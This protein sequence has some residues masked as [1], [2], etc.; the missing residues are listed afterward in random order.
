MS[1]W[2][3]MDEQIGRAGKGL[4]M[5]ADL[6]MGIGSGV[7]CNSCDGLD[8]EVLHL[9]GTSRSRGIVIPK[10]NELVEEIDVCRCID[11]AY[12]SGPEIVLLALDAKL[13]D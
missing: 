11:G 8:G 10:L 4:L 2:I 7:I 9:P 6:A 1:T 5:S 3:R 13:W 12:A